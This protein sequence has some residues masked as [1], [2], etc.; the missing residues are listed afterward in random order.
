MIK[1]EQLGSLHSRPRAYSSAP[2]NTVYAAKAQAER[3]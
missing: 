3:L 1:T 2:A